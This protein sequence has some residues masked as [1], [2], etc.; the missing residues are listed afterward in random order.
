[1]SCAADEVIIMN[2]QERLLFPKSRKSNDFPV[3]VSH[4]LLEHKSIICLHIV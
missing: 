3:F 1:M 4:I 2:Y